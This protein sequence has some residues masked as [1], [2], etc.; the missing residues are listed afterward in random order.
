VTTETI[1]WGK[2]NL[3]G[4]PAAA[5]EVE[6][7]WLADYP[8]K[9]PPT[10]LP[11][12]GCRVTRPRRGAPCVTCREHGRQVITSYDEAPSAAGKD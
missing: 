4:H 8:P 12:C 11:G 6:A 10:C 3:D 2:F 1:P 7:A 9:P 5:A